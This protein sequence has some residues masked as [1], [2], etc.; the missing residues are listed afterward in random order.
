M[1]LFRTGIIN[2]YIGYLTT[3][4]P[5]IVLGI[6][7]HGMCTRREHF[8]SFF[9]SP[10]SSV[11]PLTLMVWE[12]PVAAAVKPFPSCFNRGFNSQKKN[13]PV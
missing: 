12:V 9:T 7:W 6:S 11:L 3:S 2:S 5:P 8:L 1:Y 10:L 4:L 13:F